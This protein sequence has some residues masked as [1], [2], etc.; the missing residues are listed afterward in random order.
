MKEHGVIKVAFAL[1]DDIEV[2]NILG[3]R[4]VSTYNFQEQKS[5]RSQEHPQ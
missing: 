5:G 3:P 1:S 2:K 4:K